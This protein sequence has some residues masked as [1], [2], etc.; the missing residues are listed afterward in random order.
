MQTIYRNGSDINWTI[1]VPRP[2]ALHIRCPGAYTLYTPILPAIATHSLP[3]AF[4]ITCVFVHE[5]VAKPLHKMVNYIY[6][7]HF[8]MYV[9]AKRRSFL[10]KRVHQAYENKKYSQRHRI[11]Y[12]IIPIFTFLCAVPISRFR[13]RFRHSRRRFFCMYLISI[14]R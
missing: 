13:N 1:Y 7:F 12:A 3:F 14:V 11:Q 4:I 5:W 9:Y 8:P 6:L 10:C 2:M